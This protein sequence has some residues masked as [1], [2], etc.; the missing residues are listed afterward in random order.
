MYTH[1][2]KNLSM[3]NIILSMDTFF[4]GQCWYIVK[5]SLFYLEIFYN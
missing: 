1:T 3:D 5:A 4:W 2:D